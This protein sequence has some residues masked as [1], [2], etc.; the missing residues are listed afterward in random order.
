MEQGRDHLNR[1]QGAGALAATTGSAAFALF[2]F[3]LAVVITRGLGAAEAG[4]FFAVMSLFMIALG[5]LMIGPVQGLIRLVSHAVE[6]DRA[7]DVRHLIAIAAVPSVVLSAALGVGVAV[8]AAPI[9]AAIVGGPE[10]EPYLRTMAPLLPAAVAMHVVLAAS[11]GMGTMKP[12]VILDRLGVGAARPLLV[13]LAILIGAGPVVIGISW[14]IG[15]ALA[16]IGAW[17]WVQHLVSRISRRGRPS[18]TPVASLARSLWAFSAVRGGAAGMELVTRWIDIPLVAAL[19]SPEAAGIYAAVSRLTLAGEVALRGVMLSFTPQISA[20]LARGDRERAQG[21]YQMATAWSMAAS[22]PI[23]LVLIAYPVPLLEPFGSGFGA[24]A[25]A[26]VILCS[27]KLVATLFGPITIVLL[28]EGR[29]WLNVVNATVAVAINIGLNLWLIPMLGIEGAAIAWA[30][31]LLFLNVAPMVQ[32]YR[33]DGYQPVGRGWGVI[34]AVTT[35]TIGGLGILLPRL[36]GLSELGGLV[37][38]A[39]V[40]SPAYALLLYHQRRVTGLDVLFGSLRRSQPPAGDA[41][42]MRPR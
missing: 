12:T 40:A 30:A 25:T 31:S 18:V 11:R 15:Y 21:Y 27:A 13:G 38:F 35:V 24:G 29:T 19:A 1:S 41:Q 5:V 4:V 9:S 3:L 7:D 10:A 33:T 17:L 32:L 14:G 2:E 34:V 36:L 42:A 16:L 39:A 20:L 26:L 22:L 6:L 28:M 37:A 23:F 8:G